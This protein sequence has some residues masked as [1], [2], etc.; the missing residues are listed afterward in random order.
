M[1]VFGERLV[2][3]VYLCA[4]WHFKTNTLYKFIILFF[5]IS[6]TSL[7]SC[8]SYYNDTIHWIDN[9]KKG[10]EV[11][12]V[13][14]NQPDFVIVNWDKPDTIDNLVRYSVTKIKGNKDILRMTHYLVFSDGK[15][16]GRQSKK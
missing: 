16:Q 2:Y 15:F 12:I 1:P 10:T 5:A 11:S 4:K 9:I 7:T 13:K 3:G 14:S 6:I 8:K